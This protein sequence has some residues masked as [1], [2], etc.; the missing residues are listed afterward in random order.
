MD[1]ICETCK[2][3]ITGNSHSKTDGIFRKDYCEFCYQKQ[4]DKKNK[5]EK[6]N[7]VK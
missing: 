2:K 4:E 6:R 7:K 5:D 3:P 1:K